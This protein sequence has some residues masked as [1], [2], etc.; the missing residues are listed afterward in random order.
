MC[1]AL[2]LTVVCAV[3]LLLLQLSVLLL[4]LQLS[5]LLLL[6]L[7]VACCVISATTAYSTT[8]ETTAKNCC[9][10]QHINQNAGYCSSLC[11]TAREASIQLCCNASAANGRVRGSGFS[12]LEIKCSAPGSLYRNRALKFVAFGYNCYWS[13]Q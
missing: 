3:L 6:L 2:F 12:S 4:L 9:E 5:V 8:A 13:M 1:T 10:T 11:G 7:P